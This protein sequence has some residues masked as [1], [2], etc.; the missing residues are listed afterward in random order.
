VLIYEYEFPRSSSA[1]SLLNCADRFAAPT[2]LLIRRRHHLLQDY[3]WPAPASLS[4]WGLERAACV[5]HRLVLYRPSW[6]A[7]TPITAPFINIAQ[8]A[9][10]RLNISPNSSPPL[11]S[12]ICGRLQHFLSPK[13]QPD[14]SE[15]LQFAPLRLALRLFVAAHY[16]KKAAPSQQRQTIAHQKRARP[17]S[18]NRKPPDLPR[19]NSRETVRQE[20]GLLFNSPSRHATQASPLTDPRL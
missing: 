4:R 2:A 5:G 12:K 19:S 6:P 14:R 17:A 20:F 15:A 7:V 9:S 13:A 18:T 11:W 1:Y 10:L 8:P 16:H 3:S